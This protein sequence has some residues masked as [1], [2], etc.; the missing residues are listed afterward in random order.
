MI[1]S[2]L[3]HF[4]VLHV[5][6]V[7]LSFLWFLTKLKIA[8]L[9]LVQKRA[10]HMF[11]LFNFIKKRASYDWFCKTG[12]R[13][14]P[15]PWRHF[16]FLKLSQKL[17]FYQLEPFPWQAARA[18]Q[19]VKFYDVKARSRVLLPCGPKSYFLSLFSLFSFTTLTICF[20]YQNLSFLDDFL[21]THH[22][23]YLFYDCDKKF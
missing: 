12:W 23:K 15:W 14:Q 22:L 4:R 20:I 8:I 16:C 2:C 3:D 11:T 18:A 5:H 9:F 7:Y 21:H 19:L 17:I 10:K 13:R 6:H 1:S